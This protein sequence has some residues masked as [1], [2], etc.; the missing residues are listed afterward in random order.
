MLI[1]FLRFF[2][3]GVHEVVIPFN[4]KSG[5]YCL[6]EK[7]VSLNKKEL[8]AAQKLVNNGERVRFKAKAVD[9]KTKKEIE[10]T[11][12]PDCY[13][14]DVVFDIKTTEG[15]TKNTLYNNI[16][17]ESQARFYCVNCDSMN[18]GNVV[19]GVK[20]SFRKSNDLYGLMIIKNNNVVLITKRDYNEGIIDELLN[21]K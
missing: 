10:R 18:L 1:N 19:D 2:E 7:D 12:N 3:K 5:G 11:K 16:R 17:D 20:E 15:N 9:D 8:I 14:N 21:W 4:N 6:K 13:I